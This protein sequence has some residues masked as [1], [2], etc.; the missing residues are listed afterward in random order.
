[1]NNE[2]IESQKPDNDAAIYVPFEDI[3]AIE[4]AIDQMERAREEFCKAAEEIA[5]AN[6]ENNTDEDA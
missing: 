1:M 5:E 2:P 6:K 3:R 4:R